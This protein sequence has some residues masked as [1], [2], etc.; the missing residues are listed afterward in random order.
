MTRLGMVGMIVVTAMVG[1]CAAKQQQPPPPKIVVETAPAKAVGPPP[2]TAAEILAA[3]P[4]EVRE[5]VKE[6][7][8]KGEWPSYR[9]R[10]YMLY[11]YGEGA[12][13]VIDCAALRTTDVQLQAG[14]TVTDLAIGDQERWMATPASSGDPRNPVPHLALK[15]QAP[16]IE[17]NLTIYTTKHIYH[18]V[19]RSRTRAMQEVEFYYPEELLAALRAADDAAAKAEQESTQPTAMDPPGDT[20]GNV[21]KLA[22]VDPGQ[23][24]FSYEI[25]GP[26]V[27]WRPLRAFDD[28]SHVYLEM[29]TSMQSSAAPALLIAA[30]GGTQMVNYRVR[31]SYFVVDRLFEKG[32]LLAGVGRQQDRVVIAYA[33]GAR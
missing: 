16:G 15:P 24:N 6:H 33:G 10:T 18:L 21:V 3:Q 11:P 8:K 17:T 20:D 25:D 32:V 27:P 2:P 13:P 1:G 19:L 4:S 14:E 30:G 22:A 12:Q 9:T 28:G 23:L 31:G 7:D 5:A 29:P 26:N